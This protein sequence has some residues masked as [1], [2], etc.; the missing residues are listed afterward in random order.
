MNNRFYSA[1]LAALAASVLI[2]DPAL[3][4]TQGSFGSTSTGSVT[5]NASVPG[6]VR[7]SGLSDVTFSNVDPSVAASNAQNVCVWSNTSTRG[8]NITATGSGTANAF[9][10]A[11]G[12]LPVVPYTV[13][14]ASTSGQTSGTSLTTG[15]AFVGQTSSATNQDCSAG[16]ASSASLVVGISSATLQSMTAGATYN[17]T[18]T[19]VV[20]PE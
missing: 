1:S 17:G 18:L 6:R 12:A 5:I 19:L 20:A 11:S 8:Y 10:L 13:Q 16:P 3:A 15:T 14:W 9:T 2:A 7:I 4:S